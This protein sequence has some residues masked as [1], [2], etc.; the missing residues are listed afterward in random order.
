MHDIKQKSITTPLALAGFGAAVLMLSVGGVSAVLNAQAQNPQAQSVTSGTLSLTM[1]DN[2]VGFS[3]GISNLAP[4]DVVNRYVTLANDGSLDGQ[5][6][7]LGVVGTGSQALI[8]DGA[9]TRALTL[10]V[11][12]CS[13]AWDPTA[14]T[15]AG[16]SSTLLTNA[17]LSTLSN[18]VTL[19]SATFTAGQ[20]RH[21]QLSLVLPDQDETSTNGVPPAQTIQG[22][23]ASLT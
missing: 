12:S 8:S 21:L 16:S 17:T 13:V 1:S 4:G 22:Q 2:G 10:S 20:L 23:S 19:D 15:C 11:N 7:T 14:G 6:L 3:Q 5:N 9:L 18:A